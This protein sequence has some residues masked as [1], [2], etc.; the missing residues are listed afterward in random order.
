[1]KNLVEPIKDKKDVEAV[2]KFLEKHSLRN[3]LIWVFGTNSGLRI[4]DILK[5]NIENVRNKEY[6]ELIEKKTKKYKR[7]PLND[8]LKKLIKKYLVERDKTYAIT[9]DEPLFVGKKHHRLD[10]SQVYRI[11][12]D[13]CLHVGIKVNV[14]THTMRKTFGYHHYQKFHDVAMLQKIFNHSSPSCTL[15]YISIYQEELDESYKN[16]EL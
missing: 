4:S 8:K 11:L 16:F 13:A 7:F 12:N 1:M 10:R 9:G 3:Q 14:G 5:L 2:E 6:I 15:R